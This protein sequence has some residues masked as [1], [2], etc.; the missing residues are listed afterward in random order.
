MEKIYKNIMIELSKGSDQRPMNVPKD[1]F[2]KNFERIF[3]KKK[4]QEDTDGK[5]EN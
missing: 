2:E 5:K 1:Q 4:Q 3:G